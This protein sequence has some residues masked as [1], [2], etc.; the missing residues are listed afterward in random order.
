MKKKAS[1]ILSVVMAMLMSF[2]LAACNDT[3]PAADEECKHEYELTNTVPATCTAAGESTYTCKNCNDSYKD[4]LA[5]LGHDMP[6]TWETVDNATCT[7]NGKEKRKCMRCDYT[8]Y[9]VVQ[10][11]PHADYKEIGRENAT[12]TTDGYIEYQCVDCEYTYTETLPKGHIADSAISPVV[13]APTC[14][15][16][17][18]TTYHCSVCDEDY[19]SDYKDALGHDWVAENRVEATCDT[20]AYTVYECSRC[21][22]SKNEFTQGTSRLPHD[23][24][25]GVCKNCRKDALEVNAFISGD[26]VGIL[27]GGVVLN[28]YLA[29]ATDGI[30]TVYIE[31]G[32]LEE[33]ASRGISTF[34]LYI[35]SPDAQ[36]RALNYTVLGGEKVAF[37][38]FGLGFGN[39]GIVEV[40]FADEQGALIESM[41][42]ESGEGDFQIEIQW[43]FF[44]N[45]EDK[46]EIRGYL[47]KLEYDLFTVQNPATWVDGSDLTLYYDVEAKVWDFT[48]EA[49]KIVTI[50]KKAIKKWIADGNDMLKVTFLPKAGQSITFDVY[51]G[52]VEDNNN[53]YNF[54]NSCTVDELVLSD[55]AET[56]IKFLVYYGRGIVEGAE[57]VGY[58]MSCAPYDS[59]DP[60]NW[61]GGDFEVSYDST[62]TAW[63]IEGGDGKV[64]T[65][66]KDA[67]KTWMEQGYNTLKVEFFVAGTNLA[68]Y[69]GGE[70]NQDALHFN[71]VDGITLSD[72]TE[73][74]IKF[75][76]YN[77]NSY[78]I[79]CTPSMNA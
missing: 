54:H 2:A 3:P 72:Y 25:N 27:R 38:A 26:N 53:R 78:K 15:A 30:T 68:V 18:F 58:T 73:T 1:V 7:E 61:I 16:K 37:N 11:L 32:V 8:E 36:G 17:G 62:A 40:T 75:L 29:Y 60:A 10:M 14:T 50:N 35:G 66:N 55:Y 67:V 56:G 6:T 34:K 49:G 12:C 64:V 76:I 46:A 22:E 70:P 51:L 57:P 47:L 42:A 59:T 19:K 44:E 74:G 31:R 52:G 41:F 28:S 33:L 23:F 5:V 4:E 79:T 71:A 48:G 77:S 45:T 9:R 24:E 43:S 20:E 65:I 69:L 39:S 63:Q 21:D 13:T